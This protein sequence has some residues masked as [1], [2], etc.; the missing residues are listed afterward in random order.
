MAKTTLPSF[1][2]FGEMLRYLR[3][4]AHLTQ[5]E[6]SIA[7]GYSESQ[8]SRLEQNAR[9]PDTATLLARFVPA[10]RLE[11]EPETV[12]RLLELA[13]AARIPVP[14][15]GSSAPLRDDDAPK[16]NLP[17]RLTSFVGREAAVAT[18]CEQIV[19]ARLVTLTGVGGV[20]KSS[21]G[22]AAGRAL[23]EHFVDGVWLVELAALADPAL[24]SQSVATAFRLPEQPDRPPLDVLAAYFRQ[25]R[26]LLILDNCEH[27]LDAS[28]HLVDRLRHACSHLHILA[29]SRESLR[30]AGEIEWAV[31]PLDVPSA[32]AGA[33]VADAA[34]LHAYSA[35][36]LFVDRAR[37]VKPDFA[38]TDRAAAQ[39]AHICA[40]LDGI[41]LAIE[42][43]AARL[44]GMT[45][46]ELAARLDD[47][48]RLLTGGVRSA[49]ARHQTLRAAID[50]SYN[51]LATQE[52][53]LLQRLAVFSGGWS[54]DA[55]EAIADTPATPIPHP[56]DVLLQLVDKSLVVAETRGDTTRYRL[57]ETIRQYAAE[58]LHES[59]AAQAIYARHYAFYVKLAEQWTTVVLAGRQA[60]AWLE[61]LD[62]E[63]GNLRAAYAWSRGEDDG[64]LCALRFA[65]ALWTFWLNRGRF[66][67][68]QAWLEN[69]LDRAVT[70]PPEL[71]AGA[72]VGLVNLITLTALGERRTMVAQEGLELCRQVGDRRGMAYCYLALAR[73]AMD[74]ADFPRALD[75][76]AQAH[77]LFT[78]QNW[79]PG[80]GL[81]LS[82]WARTLMQAG[83]YARSIALADEC[84]VIGRQLED[85]YIY[86]EALELLLQFDRRRGAALYRQ[87]LALW[88][89]KLAGAPQMARYETETLASLLQTF[90]RRLCYEA[91]PEEVEESIDALEECLQ[92]W[93]RLGI[94]WS[95]P[96]GTA[97][98][99]FDLARALPFA[100]EHRRAVR[101]AQE[102]VRLYQEVGDVHGMSWALAYLGWPALALSDFDLAKRSF[103]SAIELSPDGSMNSVPRA[104]AGLAELARLQGDIA[105]AGQLYGATARY[106]HRDEPLG[107]L[108]AYANASTYLADPRFAAAWAAG[109]TM[110]FAQAIAYALE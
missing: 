82:C 45:L 65:T 19:A 105:R 60:A 108:A 91:E 22:Q 6:L 73:V 88:R 23:M 30:A 3:R 8:I 15:P 26:L 84:L 86:T 47:R 41:P 75:W 20:G 83:N 53:D 44:K 54:L 102:A 31:P 11:A 59:G 27:L 76:F 50:W 56:V 46:G 94:Q 33:G 13:S 28:V 36:H 95:P 42:L 49:P 69:S 80:A 66:H 85:L 29:T 71:R 98:A 63:L 58:K 107:D 38:L 109:E 24:L 81:C 74:L 34:A 12:T 21:L 61:R 39:A 97:R 104:L 99:Y 110:T 25:R 43:A 9:L 77:A 55:V 52:R 106:A 89:L 101:C 35:V 5:M 10:L 64:G 18:L 100:G 90:G 79:L 16:T 72:M 37:A 103:R 70:A 92:L 93:T 96:G 32:E 57:L 48:Y 78:E 7:T 67:E 87:E 40:Q 17:P 2:T 62:L 51:L 1:A 68:G 4:R 14:T